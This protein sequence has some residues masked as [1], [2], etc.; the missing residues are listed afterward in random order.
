MCFVSVSRPLPC[1]QM[2]LPLYFWVNLAAQHAE[3]KVACQVRSCALAE[4]IILRPMDFAFS[5]WALVMAD[6]RN[7]L[8]L[9]GLEG[10]EELAAIGIHGWAMVLELAEW[11]KL[12]A[13]L[14]NLIFF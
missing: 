14:R 2:P 13:Y 6:W 5:N 12:N 8:N 11:N 10:N 7:Y 4:V 3:G 9:M 1:F